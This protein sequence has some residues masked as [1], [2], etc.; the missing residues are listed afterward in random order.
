MTAPTRIAARTRL[1][2]GAALGLVV[3]VVAGLGWSWNADGIA[4]LALVS[5]VLGY[6]VMLWTGIV[7]TTAALR[8]P[9]EYDDLR[10]VPL[11]L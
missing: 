5:A 2:V 3:G 6:Y 10:N 1:G 4:L 7:Q 11:G 9:V 8:R